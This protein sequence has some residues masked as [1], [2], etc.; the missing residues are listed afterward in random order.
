MKHKFMAEKFGDFQHPAG[1]RLEMTDEEFSAE[2]ER[3]RPESDAYVALKFEYLTKFGRKENLKKYL[4]EP[5]KAEKL[6]ESGK[7]EIWKEV[8]ALEKEL[9]L[10]KVSLKNMASKLVKIVEDPRYAAAVAEDK[11]FHDGEQKK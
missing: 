2:L 1:K 9:A 5:G 7:E 6:S 11:F 3:L 4:T 8:D 10:I